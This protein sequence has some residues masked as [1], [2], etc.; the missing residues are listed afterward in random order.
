MVAA[1][2]AVAAAV[3]EQEVVYLTVKMYLP[4][5]LV[6]EMV[7]VVVLK[8]KITALLIV[9]QETLVLRSSIFQFMVIQ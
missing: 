9:L 7:F 2:A 5:C 8:M 4:G 1:A 6:A 3:A